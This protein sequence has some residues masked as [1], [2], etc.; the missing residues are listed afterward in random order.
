MAEN[1]WMPECRCGERHTLIVDD[2]V[3]VNW[4]DLMALECPRINVAIPTFQQWITEWRANW[5][6]IPTFAEF[7]EFMISQG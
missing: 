3:I 5:R 6:K 7:Q 2:M 1:Y 4:D